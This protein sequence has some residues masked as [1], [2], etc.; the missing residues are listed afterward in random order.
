M[1]YGPFRL[2]LNQFLFI[3]LEKKTKQWLN[4]LQLA[5]TADGKLASS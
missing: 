4:C 5:V 1:M 2:F 3:F